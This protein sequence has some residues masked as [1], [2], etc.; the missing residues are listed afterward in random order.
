[1]KLAEAIKTIEKVEGFD[2]PTTAVGEAWNFIVD[3]LKA[4]PALETAIDMG[5]VLG[6][7]CKCGGNC[8]DKK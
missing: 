1:M 8:K 6:H 7:E 2:D 4:N 3:C 5:I